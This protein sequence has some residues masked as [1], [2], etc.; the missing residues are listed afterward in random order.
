[1]H[2]VWEESFG[3]ESTSGTLAVTSE[4]R[5]GGGHRHEPPAP[6]LGAG[7]GRAVMYATLPAGSSSFAAA[8]PVAPKAGAFQT[9]PAITSTTHGELMIAWHELDESGKAVVVTRLQCCAEEM[10]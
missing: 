5:E 8:R 3:A 4:G 1:L 9:R 2:A 10:P 7:G 6:K